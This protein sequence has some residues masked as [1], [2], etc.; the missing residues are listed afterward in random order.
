MNTARGYWPSRALLTGVELGVFEAVAA[1][2]DTLDALAVKIGADLRACELLLDALTGLGVLEKRDDTYRVPASMAPL[3]TEGPESALP[4]L[5]H[6]ARL[7][8]SWDQL[9][10]CVREGRPAADREGFRDGA[11]AAAAFTHAMR[12]GAK[13]LAPIVAAEIPLEGRKTLLDLGG[14]PGTYAAAFARLQPSLSVVVVDLPD[15]CRA[16]EALRAEEPDVAG[17]IRYHAADL[18]HDPLPEGADAAFLSHV[19]HSNPPDEVRAMFSRIHDA[20]APGGLLVVRDFYT[21][22]DRT[23]PPGASLFALNMLVNTAGGR[24]Y[25][26]HETEAMLREAGFVDVAY[27]VSDGVP[28]AGYVFASRSGD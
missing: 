1:G 8:R 17:R 13:R 10:D 5:R 28:D 4:M 6:H 16:G 23:Q 11:E 2:A 25:S 18:L 14:G 20:L 22:D 7:W 19:I 12:V 15:V 26:T 21:N 24:T 27:R 3:L 9:T